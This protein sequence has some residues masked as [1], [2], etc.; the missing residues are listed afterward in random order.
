[1][2]CVLGVLLEKLR[3]N[4]DNFFTLEKLITIIT[5]I[6]IFSVATVVSMVTIGICN[7]SA[8]CISV[9][10]LV[11]LPPHNFVRPPRCYYRL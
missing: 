7:Y 6:T 2:A 5:F 1:M 3:W 8:C 11:S 9:V 4:A 10:I